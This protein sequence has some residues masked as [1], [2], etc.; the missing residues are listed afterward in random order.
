MESLSNVGRPWGN[1]CWI[2][3]KNIEIK[4]IQLV[5]EGISILHT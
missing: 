1:L 4:N 5:E 3:N 2:V